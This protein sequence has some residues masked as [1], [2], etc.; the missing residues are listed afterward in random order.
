MGK[1]QWMAHGHGGLCN[2]RGSYGCDGL[3]C[4]FAGSFVL[5]TII[6]PRTE[7]QQEEHSRS[8]SS[9]WPR[10]GQFV[11]YVVQFVGNPNQYMWTRKGIIAGQRGGPGGGRWRAREPLEAT[12]VWTLRHILMCIYAELSWALSRGRS[13]V[14]PIMFSMPLNC[15]LIRVRVLRRQ[16]HQQQQCRQGMWS[17]WEEGKILMMSV[18]VCRGEKRRRIGQP[19]IDHTSNHLMFAI[20]CTKCPSSSS[21]WQDRT[22]RPELKRMIRHG[23]GP[24]NG[25][26]VHK[27]QSD[28]IEGAEEEGFTFTSTKH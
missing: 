23:D 4:P 17:E 24:T 11:M 28:Q 12:L 9:N 27:S 21:P 26:C 18:Y 15:S 19:Y 1:E 13:V 25:Q 20:F 5:V 6:F 14:V 7:Q 16:Q 8:S 2:W 10:T 3:L 22:D